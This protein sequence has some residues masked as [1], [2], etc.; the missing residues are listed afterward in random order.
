MAGHPRLGR[1]ARDETR[2]VADQ[3]RPGLATKTGSA[4]PAGPG[5]C[6]G[7][8][9][10]L[11]VDRD[12]GPRWRCGAPG[13]PGPRP[14]RSR[15]DPAQIPGTGTQTGTLTGTGNH[16]VGPSV[17]RKDGP[18]TLDLDLPARRAP[19]RPF[20]TLDADWAALCRRHGR[21]GVIAH[22]AQQE[23]VLAGCRRLSDVIPPPGVDRTPY[24]RA[25]ARLS[26]AGDEL[27][28]RALLQLLVPALLGLPARWRTLG[29]LADPDG[30]VIRRAPVYLSRLNEADIACNP[31]GWLLWSVLR[32]RGGDRARRR[33]SQLNQPT[34]ADVVVVVTPP[35]DSARSRRHTKDGETRRRRPPQ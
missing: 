22:W 13:E 30:E 9:G 21:S 11:R 14:G 32:G 5:A 16:T 31:A 6:P 17:D 23:S 34:E 33:P 18:M 3:G 19:M 1:D 27:A 20:G 28:S 35:G 15:P 2:H 25:L 26:V 29:S 12:A 10:S 7:R 8:P 4:I 24:C